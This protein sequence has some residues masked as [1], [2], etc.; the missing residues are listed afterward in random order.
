MNQSVR[1]LGAMCAVWGAILSLSLLCGPQGQARASLAPVRPALQRVALDGADVARL[2]R[3]NAYKWMYQLPTP[4]SRKVWLSLWV[5]D[6][7]RTSKKPRLVGLGA[8]GGLRDAGTLAINLP[9]GNQSELVYATQFTTST[10]SVPEMKIAGPHSLAVAQEE[11]LAFDRDVVLIALTQNAS[12]THSSD[13]KSPDFM[14]RHDRTV[15]VKARFTR[16]EKAGQP[17][18][19][20]GKVVLK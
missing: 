12:G 16:G 19:N 20:A 13:Y 1:W 14:R 15:L 6:W 11:S 7:R 4:G 10:V 8:T 18:W 3:L 5:E 9:R 17:L 2:L